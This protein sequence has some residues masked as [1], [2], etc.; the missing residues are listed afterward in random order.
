MSCK[1]KATT[2]L[3]GVTDKQDYCARDYGKDV[4][5]PAQGT[6]IYNLKENDLNKYAKLADFVVKMLDYGSKA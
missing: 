1:V 3:N 5:E 6:Y 4:F 2:K